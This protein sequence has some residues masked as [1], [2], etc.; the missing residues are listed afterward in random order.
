MRHIFKT[1]I[2]KIITLEA[3][4]ALLAHK[5]RI[6]A[7]TGSVGKTSTKEAIFTVLASKYRVWKSQKSFNSEFGVPLTILG[8]D[9]GWNDPWKWAL[10]LVKGFGTIFF[11][12]NYPEWLVL[13]IGADHPGDI[14][15]VTKWLTPD[16]VVATQMSDVPVHIEY[17]SSIEEVTAEKASLAK[18]LRRGGVLIVNNDDERMNTFR[19]AT[20]AKVLSFGLNE[21]ASVVSSNDQF[22]YENHKPIGISFKANHG[23][24]SVPIQIRGS[25]G[26]Q[27]IYPVLASAAVGIAVGMNLIEIAEALRYHETPCGRMR[28]LDGI[29]NSILIDDT[30][31]S[32]PIA[33]DRALEVLGDLNVSGRKIAV[34]GD[35]LELGSHTEQAHKRMG[36][37]AGMIADI[38]VAV[39]KNCG[40]VALGARKAGMD[41]SKILEFFDANSAK[42]EIERLI[43]VGDVVLVKGS[44][45]VRMERIVE[46]VMAYPED[47][48]FL[49][50]R[51]EAEWKK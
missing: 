6:V 27:H 16:I 35:M 5:P 10:N 1:I 40:L 36:R 39:G 34:L 46:E 30:Y 32:S 15:N 11:N 44:Q 23:G 22:I 33:V 9:T 3:K 14:K 18:A 31:N 21:G 13:E 26:K 45:G 12:S 49:L 4:M 48:G 50:V 20:L 28:I 17:F 42:N 25:L 41:D 38:L 2:L 29:K 19:E 43:E 24:N 7:V 51:Q 37:H 8:L 47:K